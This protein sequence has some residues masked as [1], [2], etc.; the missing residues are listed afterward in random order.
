MKP[1]VASIYV[2][3]AVDL[4]ANKDHRI[5][6]FEDR[7]HLIDTLRSVGI[8]EEEKLQE[9]NETVAPDGNAIK[10]VRLSQGELKRLG[11]AS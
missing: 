2:L 11:L 10:E 6:T 7:D 3:W 4:G 1:R 9:L 8:V 5:Q